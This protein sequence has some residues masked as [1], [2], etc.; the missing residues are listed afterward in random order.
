MSRTRIVWTDAD[1][2]QVCDLMFAHWLDNP[3]NS[4][5]QT[6]LAI[7]GKLPENIRRS[8]S[9]FGVAQVGPLQKLY[10]TRIREFIAKGLDAAT[11]PSEPPCPEPQIVEI[12]TI[13]QPDPLTV[14]PKI[15]TKFLVAEVFERMTNGAHSNVA[16]V[17]HAAIAATPPQASQASQ[18]SQAVN[19]SHQPPS[20]P[21]IAVIGLFKPQFDELNTKL[22]AVGKDSACDLRYYDKDR[23]P[24][25]IRA[26][27]AI[28][29][30][31]SRHHWWNKARASLTHDRVYFVD[32]G[33]TAT[34]Q[35]VLDICSRQPAR[36]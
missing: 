7:R 12:E 34:M 17:V 30:R 15:P 11:N 26:D 35:K 21:R 25:P 32:G 28:V 14:L 4:P 5:Y 8:V 23:K 2:A 31:H 18:A 29:Q 9:G 33:I 3:F 19:G 10:T 13:A 6:Y 20:R 24:E 36:V 22:A 1:R 16:P 27:F